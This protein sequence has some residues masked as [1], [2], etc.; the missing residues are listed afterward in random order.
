MKL[1]DYSK[2]TKKD[3][4]NFRGEMKEKK[5]TKKFIKKREKLAWKLWSVFRRKAVAD[6]NGMVVCFICGRK[7]LWKKPNKKD[8]KVGEKCE[9]AN[10]GHFFHKI[11][12]F[13]EI[14]T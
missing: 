1:F 7:V 11:L 13:S 14:N 8:I 4:I 12:S 3:K 5:I 2:V 9:Y 6:E 10:L